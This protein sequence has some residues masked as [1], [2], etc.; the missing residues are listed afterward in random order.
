[1]EVD[2]RG[3][4]PFKVKNIDREGTELAVGDRVGFV[5][6]G[7]FQPREQETFGIIRE[8]DA[9]G[10]IK[11]DAIENYKRFTSLGNALVREKVVYFTHHVY[12]PVKRA[13]VYAKQEGKHLFSICKVVDEAVVLKE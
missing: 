1:M 6:R 7:W 2:A 8:I 13:R 11:I 10:G 5:M 12:D 3:A 4:Q 9:R